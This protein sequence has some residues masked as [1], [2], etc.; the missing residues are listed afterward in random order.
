MERCHIDLT[1]QLM[2]IEAN[3]YLSSPLS[4]SSFFLIRAAKPLLITEVICCYNRDV[5]G[6]AF[7]YFCF[8]KTAISFL[9]V[10]CGIIP[11][12]LPWRRNFIWSLLAYSTPLE[13]KLHKRSYI[14]IK[15]KLHNTQ[16]ILKGSIYSP[17]PP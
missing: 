1:K 10:C 4:S 6:T 7:K 2:H 17:V 11:H 16:P 15:F 8:W 12:N 5:F 3:P 14:W 9:V 13:L